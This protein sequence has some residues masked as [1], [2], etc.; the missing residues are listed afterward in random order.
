MHQNALLVTRLATIV[1]RLVTLLAIVKILEWKETIERLLTRRVR[2]S[3]VA[4]IVE[5]LGTS[6]LTVKNRQG[7]KPVITVARKAMCPKTAQI[8]KKTA[9]LISLLLFSRAHLPS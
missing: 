2:D 9:N 3:D 7:T 6:L 8:T 4:S 1:A 5:G